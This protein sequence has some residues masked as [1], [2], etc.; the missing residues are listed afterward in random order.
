MREKD[1]ISDN[2]DLVFCMHQYSTYDSYPCHM[3][4]LPHSHSHEIVHS[5]RLLSKSIIT[6]QPNVDIS[7]SLY[8]STSFSE[9]PKSLPY[10]WNILL[11]ETFL[12][13]GSTWTSWAQKLRA[14]WVKARSKLS[15][16]YT[17]IA[18]QDCGG[19]EG[20]RK[21]EEGREGGRE[22]GREEL[23]SVFIHP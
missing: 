16:E 10:H 11:R 13:A 17:W 14:A 20:G 2:Y 12:E 8:L 6:M 9:A 5:N 23:S 7:R 3:M 18:G 21:E 19:R 1:T 15:A 4:V 22:G